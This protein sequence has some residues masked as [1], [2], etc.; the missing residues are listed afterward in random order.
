[1]SHH[2]RSTGAATVSFSSCFVAWLKATRI[3]TDL[4]CCFQPHLELWKL[5]PETRSGNSPKHR[6][7]TVASK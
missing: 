6:V 3:Q 5:L 2:S 1:M 4:H 7:D